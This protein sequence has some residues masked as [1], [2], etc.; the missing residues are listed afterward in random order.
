MAVHPV[1]VFPPHSP[2]NPYDKPL[3]VRHKPEGVRLACQLCPKEFMG[4]LWPARCSLLEH[5]M[6]AHNQEFPM[7]HSFY[8]EELIPLNYHGKVQWFN[9]G[10]AFADFFVKWF[11]RKETEREALQE[12]STRRAE[13]SQVASTATEI[14]GPENTP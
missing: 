10:Q 9:Q 2:G 8:E 4:L 7:L 3:S 5:Y 12:P 1:E 11:R 14:I 13:P 6:K